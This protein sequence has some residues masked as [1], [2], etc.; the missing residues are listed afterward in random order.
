MKKDKS[1]AIAIPRQ[2]AKELLKKKT[3][4]TGL[5]LSEAEALEFNRKILN[6]SS[7]GILTYRK[8]GQCVSANTAAARLVGC[9]VKQ[10]LT[11]NFH[12][13]QSW[14]KSGAYQMAI[15]ALETGTEQLYD[16]H[17]VTTFGKDVWINFSFSSFDSAGEKHLL[18]FSS[19]ITGRKKAE[20][21]L[22]ASKDYLEKIINSVALP[23]FVKDDKHKFC[24]VNEALCSLLNLPIDKIIG[25]TGSGYLKEEQFKVFIAKDQEVFLTGLENIN[26]ESLSDPTGKIRSYVTRKTLYTDYKGNK[27]LVGVSYDLT[28]RK[29]AEKELKKLNKQLERYYIH[30]E[31]RKENEKKIISREIH[32]ELG[33]MLTALKIDLGWTKD[34]LSNKTE[35]K[36]R[37]KEMTDIVDET[38]KTV[39]R[40]S[41][42]LRPDILDDLGLVPTM[43][44][45]CQEFEKRTGIKCHFR[46]EHIQFTE[47][48]KNLALYRILQEALTNVARHAK[49]K[50]VSVNFHMAE[51]S[52]ILEIIDDGIDV[53][54]EKINASDSLGLIGI[55]ERVKLFNGSFD[56]K[57]TPN[58]GS[59]LTI[60]IPF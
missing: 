35:A 54:Q 14:K 58:K 31:E 7:I 44:W 9:T 51:D 41:F 10:L 59:K 2:K 5:Q 23:I 4:K 32:D 3:I 24:L 45:Y 28:E 22:Q 16:C 26:E 42:D 56:I 33:Q 25:T 20:E 18:V 13:I 6:T 29:Q 17:F 12:K 43:E 27:F 30:Q 47:E 48:K 34:N 11:Q 15:R 55:R 50:N 1:K 8:S 53:K 38:I 21:A 37:I 36:K 60:I 40:I 49:A 57:S 46:T 19:D 39:Q 52:V